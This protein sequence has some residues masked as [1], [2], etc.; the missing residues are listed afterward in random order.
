MGGCSQ[1]MIIKSLQATL[2]TYSNVNAIF[3]GLQNMHY[4]GHQIYF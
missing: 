4:I 1:E 3:S 2:H